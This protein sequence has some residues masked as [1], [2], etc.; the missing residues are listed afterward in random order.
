M[1]LKRFDKSKNQWILAYSLFDPG[2]LTTKAINI[3]RDQ[4][5]FYYVQPWSQISISKENNPSSQRDYF[6]ELKNTV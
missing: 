3:L 1:K 6:H 5:T 2:E 4:F